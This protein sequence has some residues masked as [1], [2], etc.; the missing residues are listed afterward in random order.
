[1]NLS[2]RDLSCRSASEAPLTKEPITVA[3]AVTYLATASL[4]E[5]HH[6]CF[7]NSF[8]FFWVF[9]HYMK[10]AFHPEMLSSKFGNKPHLFSRHDATW[11]KSF[12]PCCL[13]WYSFF[14][15]LLPKV[16]EIFRLVW[17]MWYVYKDLIWWAELCL[18]CL[19]DYTRLCVTSAWF[20]LR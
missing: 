4:Y 3:G 8:F 16:L 13:K 19:F 20:Y 17:T 15:F 14:L 7:W 12:K 1:M 10:L 2:R 5:S 9:L 18:C 11:N 6:S